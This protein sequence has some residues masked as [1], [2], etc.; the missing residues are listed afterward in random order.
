MQCSL[1]I[2]LSGPSAKIRVFRTCMAR[3]T[4]NV[5]S[6][7]FLW[8]NTGWYV[9]ILYSKGSYCFGFM[10]VTSCSSSLRRPSASRSSPCHEDRVLHIQPFPSK[11]RLPILQFPVIACWRIVEN[12]K[13]LWG[14]VQYSNQANIDGSVF[15][16]HHQLNP[17]VWWAPS[18]HN[19]P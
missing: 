9:Y 11:H 3:L 16:F 17:W 19:I 13:Y 5:L 14:F 12:T 7:V 10:F 8:A 4:L 2:D 15:L 6:N 1:I 18:S